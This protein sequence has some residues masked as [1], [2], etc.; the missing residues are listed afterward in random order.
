MFGIDTAVPKGVGNLGTG[1]LTDK[2]ERIVDL[3]CAMPMAVAVES[4]D[5]QGLLRECL[6]NA[7][8]EGIQFLLFPSMHLYEDAHRL[9]G[10]GRSSN[11]ASA[12]SGEKGGPE[13]P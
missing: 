10:L 6:P 5:R 3:A 1:T 2:A 7:V 11:V 8:E 13:K 9:L 4:T 12:A